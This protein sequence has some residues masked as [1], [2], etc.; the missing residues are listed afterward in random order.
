MPPTCCAGSSASRDKG[1]PTRKSP[2]ALRA[3]GGSP[4]RG[5]FF[6][7]PA[8]HAA[9]PSSS[10]SSRRVSERRKSGSIRVRGQR[11][12]LLSLPRHP[13]FLN[14]YSVGF[15]SVSPLLLAYSPVHQRQQHAG[16]HKTDI[17]SQPQQ[18]LLGWHVLD[19]QEGLEEIDAGNCHD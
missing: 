9:R 4:P 19:V 1:L 2:H 7:P 18:R 6:E 16:D 5:A 13:L 15:A 10:G 11:R 3:H 12:A 14:V 8:A 17:Q